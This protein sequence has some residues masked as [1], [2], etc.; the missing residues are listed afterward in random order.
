MPIVQEGDATADVPE[1]PPATVLPASDAS[2]IVEDTRGNGGV[3]RRL[4]NAWQA[5][6]RFLPTLGK[7]NDRQDDDMESQYESDLVNVLDTI[8]ELQ[9]ATLAR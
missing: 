4:G 8:G 2:R 6:T 1:R 5:S 9:Q 3:G 7:T